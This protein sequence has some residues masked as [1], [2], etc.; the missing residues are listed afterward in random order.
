MVL[1]CNQPAF[2]CVPAAGYERLMDKLEDRE[3]AVMVAGRKH[4]S[5]TE[6]VVE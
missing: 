5:E 2:Y 6:V 1:N 3:L 4:Q